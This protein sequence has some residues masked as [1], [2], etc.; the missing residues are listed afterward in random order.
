LNAVHVI[1][2]RA[3]KAEQA[4]TGRV[5]DEAAA[6]EAGAAAVAEAKPL[7]HNKYMVVVA[8]TL[9]KRALLACVEK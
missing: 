8:R 5:L 7:E 2:Y 9:V 3:V 4:I 1:P 6:E